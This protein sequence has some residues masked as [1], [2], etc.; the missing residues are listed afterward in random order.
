MIESDGAE[1]E[2]KKSRGQ[3]LGAGGELQNA[4]ESLFFVCLDGSRHWLFFLL[5]LECVFARKTKRKKLFLKKKNQGQNQIYAK[6]AWH[7]CLQAKNKWVQ[8]HK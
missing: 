7:K 8:A 3:Y 6:A 5:F 2:K 1:E 4:K